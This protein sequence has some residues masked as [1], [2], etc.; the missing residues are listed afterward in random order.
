MVYYSSQQT[1]HD[2]EI[3]KKNIFMHTKHLAL[4][5]QDRNET[6]WNFNIIE[7]VIFGRDMSIYSNFVCACPSTSFLLSNIFISTNMHCTQSLVSAINER[8][9]RKGIILKKGIFGTNQPNGLKA[10][11]VNTTQ[12]PTNARIAIC[13]SWSR[14]LFFFC[15]PFSNVNLDIHYFNM[16]FRTKYL[17]S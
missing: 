11:A 3:Q 14:I 1:L 4:W 13:Y 12:S 6:Q 15:D 2:C 7:Y 10:T 16:L 5:L 9:S 17:L 8:L